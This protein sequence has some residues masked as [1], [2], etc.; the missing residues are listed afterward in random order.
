[1]APHIQNPGDRLMPELVRRSDSGVEPSANR[2]CYS[3]LTNANVA[4]QNAPSRSEATAFYRA[5]KPALDQIICFLLL[6]VLAPAIASIWLVIRL[7]DG[8]DPILV[9]ER[10]GKAGRSFKMY[11]L[12]TMR[13]VEGNS[14]GCGIEAARTKPNDL[15]ITRLGRWLRR[16]RL[17]ELP[18]VLNVLRGEMSWIG[19]R[20]EVAALGRHYERTIA[21]YRLRYAVRPGISGWAQVSQGHV[22]EDEDITRKLA[23]DLH[24]ISHMSLWLDIA[25]AARTAGVVLSGRGAV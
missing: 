10:V 13:A 6:P 18:Q 15:R 4:R 25:I 23:L 19:P 2:K 11:K 12:R 1:M 20:P 7:V 22:I 24:Y 9:Q 21:G 14:T 16:F 8:P 3:L 17:D 5:I